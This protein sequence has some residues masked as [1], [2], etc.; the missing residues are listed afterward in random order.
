M[1]SSAGMIIEE[2]GINE[3]TDAF[4]NLPL[5]KVYSVG[6]TGPAGGIVFYD[7]GLYNDGWRYMEAAPPSTEFIDISWGAY[8]YDIDST[9][10]DIGTG[11]R[12]TQIINR[13]LSNINE[14]GM[15]T[16]LCTRLNYNGYNDWF[17]PS[18]DELTW[19]YNNLAQNGLGGF[20]NVRYWSSSQYD[21]YCAWY[22][23]FGD[24]GRSST[25]YNKL[26]KTGPL[27]LITGEIRARAI[28]IF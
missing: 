20:A 24:N 6:E 3:A 10:T 26:R 8:K 22:I 16:Q 7:K 11:N 9:S 5:I 27:G 23:H 17:L 28:R 14:D 2:Y 25:N 21:P 1:I 15:I 12:N 19:L 18:K 13:F 4:N